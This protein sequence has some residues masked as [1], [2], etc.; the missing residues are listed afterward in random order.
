MIAAG[1]VQ[2][3]AAC[4]F[5][6]RRPLK[7]TSLQLLRVLLV[8]LGLLAVKILLHT[9][10]GWQAPGLR[11][12]PLA[13]DTLVAPLFY[14]YT[15]SLVNKDFKLSKKWWPHVAI[16]T[17][18]MVHALVVYGVTLGVGDLA[19]KDVM[20]ASM[21]YN[22]VKWW[23]DVVTLITALLYWTLSW[24]KVRR[25]RQW[26]FAHESATRY[27]ELTWLR[28]LLLVTAILVILLT[29]SSLAA[30]ILYWQGSFYYL[31][32]FYVYLILLIYYLSYREA[33]WASPGSEQVVTNV[34]SAEVVQVLPAIQVSEQDNK[35]Q[36]RLL[37]LMQEQK[38]YLDPEL[39]LATL[40][41][42]VGAPATQVSQVINSGLGQNFRNW[43]N[44]YR[45][46]EVKQRLNDPAFA[47]LNMTGIAFDCGFN[48]EASFYRIF[49]QFTGQSPKSYSALR[50][51]EP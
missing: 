4:W 49:R 6:G 28:N 38:P 41:S 31:V 32:V 45:V 29:V 3:I 16:P 24:I 19:A 40:A 50:T 2:A 5:L 36:E 35:L 43:V 14:A 22:E 11:Y 9:A 12:F 1:V 33:G 26:L 44:G 13:I 30:N 17:I 46:E 15:G 10:G 27:Q 8:V 7:D 39:N 21:G 51:K 23:E 47:H 18:F 20:A 34:P 25:Y 42:L 37:Q 48:S